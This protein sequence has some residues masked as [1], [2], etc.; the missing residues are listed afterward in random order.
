[1]ANILKSTFIL[2]LIA[3][4]ASYA[5]SHVNKITEPEILRQEKEKQQNALTSVLPGYSVKDEKTVQV[6]GEDFTYWTGEKEEGESPLTGYAFVTEKSGYSGIVKTMVGVDDKG[7]I[8]GVSILQQSETPGLGARSVEIAST[9]TFWQVLFGSSEKNEETA[10]PWF[11]EQFTGLD[12]SKP[13]EIVKKG[14]WKESMKAELLEKN[15][16]SAITGATI[17]TRTVKDS[18]EAGIMKF[19]EAIKMRNKIEEVSK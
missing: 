12:G 18:I 9:N 6:Q 5:L 7:R 3:F 8:L 15:A 16:I 19:N 2:A 10:R 17:T 11:Q 14:D 4:I 13:I 1:M